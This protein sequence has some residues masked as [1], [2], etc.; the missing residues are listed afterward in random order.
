MARTASRDS[1]DSQFFIMFDRSP[2]LDGKYSVWGR[3][4]DGMEHVDTIKK[5]AARDNGSV[6]DPD[7]IIRL[8]VAADVEEQA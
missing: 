3:V 5:G 8:R 2:H 1:A 7:Q 6:E 4:V